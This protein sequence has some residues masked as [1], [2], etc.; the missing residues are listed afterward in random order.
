MHS[1]FN[2]SSSMN[3]EWLSS[4]NNKCKN[5][6]ECK[7]SSSSRPSFIIAGLGEQ[8][9]DQALQDKVKA[10]IDSGASTHLVQNRAAFQSISIRDKVR[11]RGVAGVSFGYRGVLKPTIFGRRISAVYYRDL[12]V[13]ALI[14]VS[15]LVSQGW[16]VT[17]S[18]EGAHASHAISGALVKFFD[19]DGLPCISSLVTE[20]SCGFSYSTIDDESKVFSVEQLVKTLSPSV[21]KAIVVKSR[22][23]RRGGANSVKVQLDRLLQHWRNAHIHCDHHKIDCMDCKQAKF[24]SVGADKISSKA[25]RVNPALLLFSTDFFC[26][27]LPASYRGSVVVMLF[28]CNSSQYTVVRCLKSKSFAPQA[29]E[30]FLLEIRSKCGADICSGA[31][32]TDLVACGLR[33]DNEETLKSKAMQ[34]MCL[35]YSVAH[36]F[37][38]PYMPWTNSH[39]E[40]AV[41]SLKNALRSTMMHVDPRVWDYGLKFVA[42]AWNLT[43]RMNK[44]NGTRRAPLEAVNRKCKNPLNRVNVE[45]KRKYLRRFGCLVVFRPGRTELTKVHE[46]NAV[47]SPRALRGIN[48]GWSEENS[49]WL[50]GC[51]PSSSSDR[52]SVYQCS[53]A[54]FLEEVMVSDVKQLCDSSAVGLDEQILVRLK[55]ST[56]P[57]RAQSAVG[58][59]RDHSVGERKKHDL[60]GSEPVGP[61]SVVRSSKALQQQQNESHI[62]DKKPEEAPN[63][64]V[65][66]TFELQ[67]PIAS[68]DHI[69]DSKNNKQVDATGA[70]LPPNNSGTSPT[71]Q[72]Q[73]ADIV[74]G[75]SFK[76]SE[77]P[78]KKQVIAAKKIAKRLRDQQRAAAAPSSNFVDEMY[79]HLAMDDDE[80]CI[81][82]EIF[83][84]Q[85]DEDDDP[86]NI[87]P[88]QTTTPS[89]A[90]APDNPYR[91]KWI[92]ATSIEAARLESYKCWRKLEPDDYHL[93]RNRKLKST[94]TALLLNRKRCGRYK[95]RLVVLGNRWQAEANEDFNLYASVVSQ[96][97]NR[98][99]L[100]SGA[101]KKWHLKAFDI[102]NAFIR[103]SIQS[104]KV[105]V[106]I[107]PQFRD[108]ENDDGLRML[109]KALYGLPISPRLW[110]DQI[111]K[112]LKEL[113][114]TEAEAEPGLW[115]LIENGKIVAILTIY[116]DDCIVMA[117]S[118]KLVDKLI[119][120]V[121]DKHPVSMI[122][123]K[124]LEEKPGAVQFDLLGADCV[125]HREAGYLR[126]SM[127]NYVD[128]ILRKFDMNQS[129]LKSV[130]SPDFEEA[131]LYDEKS[132]PS[133]IKF[134]AVVGALQWL[135]VTAR[136]DLS[137]ATNKLARA[138]A[139]NVNKNMEAAARRVLRYV[140]GTRNIGIEYSPEIEANFYKN[141][142]ALGEHSENKNVPS[143]L[144][145]HPV[146]TYGDAS[147]A[148]TFKTMRSVSGV[149]VYLYGFPV[150]WKSQPQSVTTSSSMEAEWVAASTAIEISEGPQLL[151]QFLRGEIRTESD[152]KGPVLCDNRSAVLSGRKKKS[153]LQRATRHVAI[154]HSKVVDNGKRIVFVPTH[155]QRAD[156]L[157]KT[158][159]SSALDLIFPQNDRG[160]PVFSCMEEV[161]FV[162]FF[163][164]IL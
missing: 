69:A 62:A 41:Q 128:K 75:P 12:P 86:N 49:C 150:A 95:A 56:V 142:H 129:N 50:V 106:S 121:H 147:Y 13:P 53:N 77:K 3:S 140:A 31:T 163:I 35:R 137:S 17:F 125:Y 90:F 1:S 122:E 123:M 159:N 52:F 146:T 79:A 127:A 134:R 42:H 130:P 124:K 27:V 70:E 78:M 107:P 63:S 108:G 157:T 8:E 20:T 15:K 83:L 39:A 148:S 22:K 6:N 82:A 91:P 85:D 135:C 32:T 34:E 74:H 139:N 24:R 55:A 9:K 14:S 10:I 96:V 104:H 92:E 126:I 4:E 153:E 144:L 58:D 36:T 72:K 84:A 5:K 61:A 158:S 162:G 57:D 103:A 19:N 149:V 133:T 116:V 89:K 156:G 23:R 141:L 29:L 132:P 115:R 87:K 28:V 164:D 64:Q 30:S 68:Q 110:G 145:D 113:G 51:F 67:K 59:V 100:V 154:R 97:G 21:R 76:R 48:L 66:E 40:R 38:V 143:K 99:A 131:P 73:D 109:L 160:Q 101:R 7:N 45:E 117:E 65:L 102:G 120:Q 93:L 151:M 46:K 44:A 25:Q 2:K 80:E 71:I 98:C 136:P 43:P 11:I 152:E 112:D 88:G 114:W 105:I 33:S 54:V 18:P 155:L 81:S 37:S 138:T 94:P 161:D 111:S 47:L 119:K 26:P 16:A 118:E 60:E